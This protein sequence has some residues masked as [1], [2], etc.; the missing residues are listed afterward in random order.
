MI[1]VIALQPFDIFVFTL[2]L[3]TSYLLVTVFQ[4]LFFHPLSHVPGPLLARLSPWPSA[5]HARKGNR[6]L[7]LERLF[8]QYG[9]KIRITPDCVLFRNP[10]A[11]RDI[12]NSRAN[13]RRADF[14]NALARHEKELNTFTSVENAE[15]HRRRRLLDLAFTNKSLKAS[16]S[17]MQHHIDRWHE[18][19]LRES[20]RGDWTPPI[21]FTDWANFLVFDILGDVCFGRSFGT[22]EPDENPIKVVPRSSV[23]LMKSM[24]M[25]AKSPFLRVVRYLRPK[26]LGSLL[27]ATRD[28]TTL[29]FDDF[30]EEST[31]E[32]LRREHREEGTREDMV[33][34]L[35]HAKDPKTGNPGY[36]EKSLVAELRLII[37][38]GSD[39]T[40]VTLSGL[41]FYL[42][43]Y[44]HVLKKLQQEI[45]SAFA[46]IGEIEP[47]T[48]L[49]SCKYTRACIDEA[50]RMSPAG[51]SELPRTVLRG[52]ITIDGE[53]YPEGITVGTAGWADN[54][55]AQVYGDPEIFRPERW[56]ISKDNTAEQVSQIKANFHPFSIGP[57]NCAGMSFALQEL[58]LVVAKTIYKLEFRLAPEWARGEGA[59]HTSSMNGKDVPCFHLQ[60]AFIVER[61]GPV[62]QFRKRQIVSTP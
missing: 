25:I 42:S 38:A 18:L 33:H 60:D 16:T 58:M 44:P 47:G 6:H 21:N 45:T 55:N 46:S 32:R 19:T 22:K 5:Y 34:F 28:K 54:R 12:Y 40:S 17:F 27:M 7:W 2:F 57:H 39:S 24:Y 43:H 13:V 35:Y 30:A 51:L 41:L 9:P 61:D 29:A 59:R 37:I 36:D 3:T 15:H 23:E 62:L 53:F 4:S 49:S 31:T 52:G 14:Y 56:L 11:H 8:S 48:K 50:L 1:S 20:I 10:S 26:G